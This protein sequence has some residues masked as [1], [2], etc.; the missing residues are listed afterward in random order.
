MGIILVCVLLLRLFG[1]SA[2][3]QSLLEAEA[4]RLV[5]EAEAE[6]EAVK[7]AKRPDFLVLE[8]HDHGAVIV[9]KVLPPVLAEV[10]EAEGLK[11]EA[12]LVELNSQ[13]VVESR[14]LRLEMTVYDE[15]V[16]EIIWWGPSGERITIWSN[17]NFRYLSPFGRVE[18]AGR[19]YQ[20]VALM[21]SRGSEEE[22]QLRRYLAAEGV[23]RNWG[24]IPTLGAFSGVGAEYLVFMDSENPVPQEL[25]EAMEA[26][27]GFYLA[28]EDALRDRIDRAQSLEAA[29]K[30][31]E[32]VR[33][34][35]NEPT[36]LHYWKKDG[37]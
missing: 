18:W 36:L 32:A 28:N 29:R 37:E 1:V 27:H 34:A 21:Q 25:D 15:V 22:R 24:E 2:E 16:T 20:L 12:A 23:Q 14:D 8:G 10:K 31:L 9:R 13:V 30:R 33:A 19:R 3:G 11:E 6:R 26:L 7:A 17:L 5:R 35:E 4:D